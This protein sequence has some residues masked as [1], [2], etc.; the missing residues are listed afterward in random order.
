[1]SRIGYKYLN[2]HGIDLSPFFRLRV[3]AKNAVTKSKLMDKRRKEK[4]SKQREGKQNPYSIRT[5]R[6]AQNLKFKTR[7]SLSY[8]PRYL[9]ERFFIPR[10]GGGGGLV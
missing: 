3:T 2:R 8:L 10:E 9:G 6:V 5:S 7:F 4:E 1:M